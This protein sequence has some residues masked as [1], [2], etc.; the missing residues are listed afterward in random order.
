[1][2]NKKTK[3]SVEQSL[4]FISFFLL[5]NCKNEKNLIGLTGS[6]DNKK[7]KFSLCYKICEQISQTKK[8]AL[9]DLDYSDELTNS[10]N[11]S[12]KHCES[13]ISKIEF[14]KILDDFCD[15]DFVIMNAPCVLNNSKS[16][17][18]LE[19]CDKVFMVERYMYTRYCDYEKSVYLL[20]MGG[21]DVS[22]VISYD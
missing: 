10:K 13:D 21:V 17:F 19:M 12:I 20:K 7:M 18:Y 16:L 2:F 14:K 4:G 5:K 6:Y 11:F 8:V 1:M 3:N 15:R 9:L 22:G